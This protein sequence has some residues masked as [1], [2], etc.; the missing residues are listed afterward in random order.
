MDSTVIKDLVLNVD[1]PVVLQNLQLPWKCFDVPFEE[2]LGHLDK[3]EGEITFEC[4]SKRNGSHP[5]WER[6][7][8]EVRMTM[9]E[10][11]ANATTGQGHFRD[12]WASYSYR[13]VGELPEI[14][15]TGIDFSAFGFPEI[16][17]DVSFWIGTEGAHTPCHYDT[18]GCN[19]VVQV[20]GRKRWL[21]FPPDAKLT[22]TRVPYEESSV[23]CEQNFYS[24][25][26]YPRVIGW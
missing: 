10:F 3:A 12:N 21:L 24:P 23:Y 26:A 1:K 14:C 8:S 2:W 9:A 16:R 13:S 11:F 7:R 17:D 25:D 6:T 5:Q 22:P 15:R 20:R 19:I 4:G 18:Y